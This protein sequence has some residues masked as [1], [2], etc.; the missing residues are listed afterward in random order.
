[1]QPASFG[2]SAPSPYFHLP[3]EVFGLARMAASNF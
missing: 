1:M 3:A 2:F